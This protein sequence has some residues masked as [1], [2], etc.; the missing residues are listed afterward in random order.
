LS[1]W[2][3]LEP[4]PLLD[5]ERKNNSILLS[6]NGSPALQF[7]FNENIAADY[8]GLRLNASEIYA[9]RVD[10]DFEGEETYCELGKF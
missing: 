5:I 9:M 3:K 2:E 8:K 1:F 10:A 6:Y 7:Y 4:I